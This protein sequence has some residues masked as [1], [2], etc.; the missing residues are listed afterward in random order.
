MPGN[1]K[2]VDMQDE[3]FFRV[4]IARP[5]AVAIPGRFIR[6]KRLSIEAIGLLTYV[7]YAQ[8]RGDVTWQETMDR[9][10]LSCEEIE[11]LDKEIEAAGGY[12]ESEKPDL[13]PHTTR[14]HVRERSSI[15]V[16]TDGSMT[17]VGISRKVKKRLSIIRTSCS[18]KAIQL[19]FSQ[20]DDLEVVE[21]AEA[22]AH[23]RLRRFRSHG[24]WFSVDPERAIKSVKGAVMQARKEVA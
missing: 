23:E 10:G 5:D 16:I 19:A 4:R 11:R 12:S 22:I 1:S 7:F 14:A 24:E 18:N 6:D 2:V 8:E 20:E 9:F 3:D 13:T 17:K 21:R 15:Y